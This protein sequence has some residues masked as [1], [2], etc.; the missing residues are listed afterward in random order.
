MFIVLFSS[1]DWNISYYLIGFALSGS[2]FEL[3]LSQIYGLISELCFNIFKCCLI[4][5]IF[6]IAKESLHF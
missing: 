4:Y 1:S 3:C 5:K 6:Y 2:L